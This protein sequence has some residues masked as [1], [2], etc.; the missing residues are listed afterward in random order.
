MGRFLD[1][2]PAL[3]AS[4]VVTEK[5]DPNGL[6]MQSSDKRHRGDLLDAQKSRN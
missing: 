4:V 3:G 6:M 2:W 5:L 1:A